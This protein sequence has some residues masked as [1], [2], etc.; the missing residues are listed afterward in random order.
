M[1]QAIQKIGGGKIVSGK[2]GHFVD[3]LQYAAQGSGY[4]AALDPDLAVQISA[5]IEGL[6]FVG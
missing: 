6:A 2:L 4:A 3:V 5:V 1:R